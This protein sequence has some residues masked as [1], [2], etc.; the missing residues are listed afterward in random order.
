MYTRSQYLN[1]ECTHRQF[2]LSVAETA[3]ITFNPDDALRDKLYHAWIKDKHFNDG[4]SL[5]WWDRLAIPYHGQISNALKKHG[6]CL[7][8]AGCVSL[9]KTLAK[10][11]LEKY[12]QTVS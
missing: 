3:G 12:H 1:G 11:E 4:F 9:Y 8:L 10:V 5:N 6:D 2:Y 7:S